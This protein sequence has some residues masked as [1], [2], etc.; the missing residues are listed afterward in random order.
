MSSA[1]ESL[2]TA[3]KAQVLAEALPWL[4]QLHGNNELQREHAAGCGRVKPDHAMAVLQL[5]RVGRHP[6]RLDVA[7]CSHR[8]FVQQGE[9][10]G[11]HVAV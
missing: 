7:G 2:P 1:T 6:V 3:V 8:R 10:S 11:Y 5:A 9:A 4:K